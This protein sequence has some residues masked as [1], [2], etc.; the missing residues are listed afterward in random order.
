MHKH[1]ITGNARPHLHN[2]SDG[3]YGL[4]L[5]PESYHL[6]E[7]NSASSAYSS[8]TT[9]C[10]PWWKALCEEEQGWEWMSLAGRAVSAEGH[11]WRSALYLGRKTWGGLASIHTGNT[12]HARELVVMPHTCNPRTW[13]ARGRRITSHPQ[14]YASFRANLASMR[15][16]SKTKQNCFSE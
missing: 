16:I 14:L 5:L 4:Q 8:R 7:S 13:K 11:L 10:L 9:Q 1:F 6:E 3:E 12:P 15:P 2:A